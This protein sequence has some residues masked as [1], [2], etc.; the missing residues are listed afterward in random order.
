ME[1]RISTHKFIL[2]A[3]LSIL[4]KVNVWRTPK[5]AYSLDCLIPT[6]MV[7]AAIT[8]YSILVPLLA[9]MAELLQWSTWTG[10]VM[11]IP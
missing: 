2:H 3:V 5:Q 8:W 9:F 6:V 4:G 7:W 1:E 11:Y 10:W